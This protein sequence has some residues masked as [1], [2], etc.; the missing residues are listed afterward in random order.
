MHQYFTIVST[1]LNQLPLTVIISLG[2]HTPRS[3]TT[4][5]SEETTF[6]QGENTARGIGRKRS[7]QYQ[8]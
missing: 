6:N 2:F 3:A 5:A 8:Q 7:H 1:D 4:P